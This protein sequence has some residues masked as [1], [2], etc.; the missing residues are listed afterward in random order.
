M[1]CIGRSGKGNRPFKQIL[2]VMSVLRFVFLLPARGCTKQSNETAEKA[3]SVFE[4]W[5]FRKTV[6]PKLALISPQERGRLGKKSTFSALSKCDITVYFVRGKTKGAS[7][8]SYQRCTVL[9]SS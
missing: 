4:K 8:L 6:E 5:G 2:V 1:I 3:P 7:R 9:L